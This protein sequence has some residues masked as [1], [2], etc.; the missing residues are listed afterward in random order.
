[1]TEED[2]RVMQ[3]E[4][5]RRIEMM[6]E[7]EKRTYY[8]QLH[9]RDRNTDDN[10]DGEEEIEEFDFDDE[11]KEKIDGN[12]SCSSEDGEGPSEENSE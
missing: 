2:K 8:R 10:S 3:L 1:M 4:E 6:T 9:R 7:R 12:D 11:N 5:E